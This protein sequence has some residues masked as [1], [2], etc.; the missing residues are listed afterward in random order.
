M[1]KSSGMQDLQ[2]R[3]A[4][5]DYAFEAAPIGITLVDPQG[6]II[7]ANESFAR[8][9]GLSK[10]KLELKPFTDFTHPDDLHIDLDF[11]LEVLHRERD[12]YQTEKRYLRADGEIVYAALTVTAMRNAQG[13]VVRFISQIEDITEKKRAERELAERAA[14]LELVME[15]IRGGFW[16]M[17]VETK[18]FETSNRL[19]QF[20]G[21]PDAAILD[22]EDY[23]AL[24]MP[25]D[26]ANA[27]LADLLAGT[28]DQ[29]VAEY[30][31]ATRNGERWMRC[32]RRLLRDDHGK[33]LRIVG[34][35]MD[36][37]AEHTRL[38]QLET[39]ADT[40]ALT[41]LL[42]R[43]G[44]QKSF[45]HGVFGLGCGLLAVDLDGFKA[46]N[47]RFGHGVGDAVL[48][49]AALRL[50]RSVRQIDAIARMGGDEFL[51]LIDG[52]DSAAEDIATRIVEELRQP[53]ELGLHT[54]AVHASVGG[55]WW[56]RKPDHLRE[57][58]DAADEK[59]YEAKAAGKNTWRLRKLG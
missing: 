21:G 12:S 26:R 4:L 11:F 16:H 7:K 56:P 37:T 42:N 14:Q 38:E 13:A 30:R 23:M 3:S 53:I 49:E 2:E 15:A 35:A 57:R 59:L 33:P 52:P 58:T 44:I 20:I 45:K 39:S 6:R 54:I 31:L 9:L 18:Y 36:M 22:L 19:A 10:T 17:D 48:V 43:R 27:S 47:D 32:D 34:V 55:A 50:K 8:M 51:V 28:V 29:S 41:S 5:F 24:V 25:S 40:D 46:V 1:F